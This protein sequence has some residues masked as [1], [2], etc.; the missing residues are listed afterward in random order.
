MVQRRGDTLVVKLQAWGTLSL[1][2]FP[3]PSDQLR[4][5]AFRGM[6]RRSGTLLIDELRYIGHEMWLIHPARGDFERVPCWITPSRTSDGCSAA[7]A[8][9]T[10]WEPGATWRSTGWTVGRR[11]W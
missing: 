3:P 6:L 5:W 8:S 1:V 11:S 10:R 7:R 2:D 9:W 4:R